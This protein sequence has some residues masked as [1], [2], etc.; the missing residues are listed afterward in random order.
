MKKLISSLLALGFITT[1]VFSNPGK[2]RVKG[3]FIF[4]GGKAAVRKID[5][6]KLR[7][8]PPGK[9]L[10]FR[11]KRSEIPEMERKFR[12]LKE[13]DFDPVVQ[14]ALR[15]FAMPSPLIS[16][17]GLDLNNW[18]A[19]W[20]PDTNGDVGK[21]NVEAGGSNK[22]Y[23]IQTVNTSI[24][25]FEKDTGN[26]VAA[27]TFDDFFDGTGTACDNN[28]YGDPIVLYDRYLDRWIITDFA[29]ADAY[30]APHYE[31]VAMSM[32]NDPVNGG[33]YM[34][35][36]QIE[37]NPSTENLLNDYPKLGVWR[38]G[39]YMTFNMFDMSSGGSYTG[40]RVY[41]LDKNSM[42]T[43]TLNYIYFDLP[44]SSDSRNWSLLPANAKS[45]SPPPSG[46]P[47]YLLSM[48]DDGWSD[49]PDGQ[50]ELLLWKFLCGL[51]NTIQFSH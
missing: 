50:D 44:Y 43:G 24:G 12:F 42:A 25:I 46:S 8:L 48:A 29:F 35:G 21:T 41:A 23:Y 47:N 11:R 30:S 37:S 36:I 6:R 28:N 27:F 33:W 10:K 1:V 4:K 45:P 19:G 16:F 14:T 32:T 3:P 49:N 31:C 40:V 15:K 17:D 13:R 39:Y 18:G 2:D 9:F 38:D 22:G 7:Q 51:D 5:L 34:W 26:L 20:P